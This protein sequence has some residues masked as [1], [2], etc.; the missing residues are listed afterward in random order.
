M[1]LKRLELGPHQALDARRIT[2]SAT[3]GFSRYSARY[4]MAASSSALCAGV[5]SS[6]PS[7]GLRC[8]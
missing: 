3:G 6:L 7:S 1:G 5:L 2:G 8:T 4:Q